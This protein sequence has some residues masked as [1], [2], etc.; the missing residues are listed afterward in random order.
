MPKKEPD[1]T[2]LRNVGIIAHIDAGKT[3]CTERILLYTGRI[4]VA[5]EVHKGTATMDW[6]HDERERGIT[7]TAAATT[8]QWRKHT[9]NILDTPGHVDFTAEVERSLR[10]LDGA[11][12][13]FDGKHGVEAQSETVWRQADKYGV[14]RLAFINKLDATGADFQRSVDSIRAKLNA[15]P[16]PIAIPWGEEEAFRGI[17]HVLRMKALTFEG[18][19]GENVV[20]HD[21][22]DD[23]V[24]AVDMAREEL[25]NE[26]TAHAG[27]AGEAL[28]EKFLGGEPIT[29]DDF[30]APL[31]AATLAGTLIPVLC[32]SALKN[33]GVQ[34][35]LDAIVDYLPSPPDLPPAGGIAPHDEHLRLERKPDNAAP[36]AALAF[37]LFHE[38]YGDLTYVRI[39]SG[40]LTLGS[41]VYNPRVGKPERVGKIFA[42][43]ADRREE[44]KEATAGNIVAIQG[45]RWTATGDTICD[46]GAPILFEP[47]T[48]PQTVV[49]RA[50]EPKSAA[51]RDKMELTIAALVREDPTFNTTADP[52]TG[53]TLVHG[54][55]ELH[56]EVIRSRMEQEFNLIVNMGKPRVGYR[57]TVTI[58]ALG[59]AKIDRQVGEK[60]IYGHVIAQIEPDPEAIA[61]PIVTIQAA[62]IPQEYHAAVKEGATTGASSGPQA[63]YPVI[64]VRVT[65]V[66]GGTREGEGNETGFSQA[67]NEAVR[68]A[69]EAAQPTLLEP[70]MRFQVTVPEAYFGSVST[71]LNARRAE[72]SDV[73][74]SGDMRILFGTV[75][76][77]ETFGYTSQ[78]R[79]LSQGRAGCSLEPDRYQVVPPDRVGE[80]LGY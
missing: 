52:E 32:G 13:I 59:E 76:L 15:N 43:H 75:P 77:A 36:M 50:V 51:D 31:R 49:T 80:L 22:P 78:L 57:E 41:Q 16:V 44:L 62:G 19:H 55:G 2:T 54:M 42:M 46:K 30:R 40:T 74:Q 39:Y 28:M 9:I 25:I 24:D 17:V 14:P 5:G 34:P 45:L 58:K 27:D 70:I 3:T 48:F 73:Q 4:R 26:V 6:M 29:A 67:A 71:D 63:G 68:H 11:V 60:S 38:K 35:L 23:L 20:E 47:P 61:G 69:L 64:H 1:P 53:E 65:I 21:I 7:I 18:E 56:L 8:C 72:I 10:V 33:I 12:G 37:K 79:S 66:G